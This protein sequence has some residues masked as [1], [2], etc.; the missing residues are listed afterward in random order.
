MLKTKVMNNKKQD[1]NKALDELSPE[2]KKDALEYKEHITSEVGYKLNEKRFFEGEEETSS[3]I[4]I[5]SPELDL[6]SNI[7]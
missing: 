2:L 7:K 4:G 6:I 1:L 5:T 3:L